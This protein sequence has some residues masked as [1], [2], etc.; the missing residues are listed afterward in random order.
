MT[1]I[2]L[3]IENYYSNSA[4]KIRQHTENYTLAGDSEYIIFNGQN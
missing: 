2:I 4:A 1:K 3:S